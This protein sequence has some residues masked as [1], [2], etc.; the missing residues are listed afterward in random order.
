MMV[1]IVRII[2]L[3]LKDTVL[4]GIQNCAGVCWYKDG[5]T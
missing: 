3:T 5:M 2:K 1:M 4:M